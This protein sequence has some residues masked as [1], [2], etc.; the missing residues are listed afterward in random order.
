MSARAFVRL[1]IWNVLILMLGG[2]T[3]LAIF[4]AIAKSTGVRV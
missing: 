3:Q 4:R 1:A 2:W